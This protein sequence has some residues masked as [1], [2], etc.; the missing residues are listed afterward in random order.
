MILP[1]NV[2]LRSMGRDD[3]RCRSPV[4][5]R[6]KV[7]ITVLTGFLVSGETTLLNHMSNSP[8]HGMCFAIIKNEFG[9]VRVDEQVITDN[10]N[11]ELIEVIN[12]CIRCTVRGALVKALKGCTTRDHR[13][14]SPRTDG[15][16]VLP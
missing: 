11:E 2:A 9:E 14:R 13:A 4:D 5:G 1:H 16:D 15:T 10:T 12:G 6:K 8:D 7:P 3:S